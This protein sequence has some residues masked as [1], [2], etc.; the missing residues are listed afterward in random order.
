MFLAIKKFPLLFVFALFTAG[1]LSFLGHWQYQKGQEREQNDYQKSVSL[2]KQ[3]VFLN[4]LT[5]KTT[6]EDGL[7]VTLKGRFIENKNIFH[8]NRLNSGKSGYHV[9]S[10][11]QMNKDRAVL[12]NRGWVAMNLDRRILPI[13]ET[14]GD[15]VLIKGLIRFPV[16]GV[17]TLAEEKQNSEFPQRLQTIEVESLALT[18]QYPLQE[19]SVLLGEE[20]KGKHFD[21]QWENLLPGKY[22]SADK[23]YAYSLQWFSLALI[24]LIIFMILIFKMAK[25]EQ[26]QNQE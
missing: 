18:T 4:E 20:V 7:R 12:V 19:Y 5:D 1:F 11:F 10:I 24:G 22:M 15:E 17:Y 21:R 2:A 3:N 8:D 9:F 25:N 13:I 16:K 6:L 14:S 26:E 23:H